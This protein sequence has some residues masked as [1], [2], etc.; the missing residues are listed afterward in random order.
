MGILEDRARQASEDAKNPEKRQ[1][2]EDQ[3]EKRERQEI[4]RS[5]ITKGLDALLSFIDD[6]DK[7]PRIIYSDDP[8]WGAVAKLT[9]SPSQFTTGIATDARGSKHNVL[10]LIGQCKQCGEET[11]STAVN[12]PAA[13][14]D[15]LNSFQPGESHQ[16]KSA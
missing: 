14:G 3:K 7:R 1:Q 16:C 15:L 13:Y 11:I 5:V 6:R 9:D 2:E 10:A 8:K 12:S 4:Q